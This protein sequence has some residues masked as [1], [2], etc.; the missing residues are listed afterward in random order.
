[1][2]N[3]KIIKNRFEKSLKNYKANAV[4]QKSMAE[5]LAYEIIKVRADYGNVLELG[6]GAGVLTEILSKSIVFKKYYTNDLTEKSENYVRKYLKDTVFY[7]GNALK[8][9]PAGKFD[10][11]VSNAMFQW[12]NL[13]DMCLKAK[14]LLSKDGILAFSTFGEDNCK[15]IRD[16]TGL[17]L[18][19][20]NMDEIIS[21]FSKDF[22]I[23]CSKEQKTFMEFKTPLELLA[24]MKNTGVNSL[25]DTCWTIS[26]VK[27][28][29]DKYSKKYER[30]CLTYSPMIFVMRLK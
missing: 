20:K 27:D 6:C 30:V 3:P 19:Y 7:A 1:M 8:I 22:D 29:C 14:H 18:D 11:I 10:L 13:A 28:F 2:L 25:N 23:L 16:I 4:V 26:D 21:I 9:K 17:T 15:E 5:D 24:H 12:L